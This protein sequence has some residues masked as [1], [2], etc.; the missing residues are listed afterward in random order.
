MSKARM[1]IAVQE[2]LHHKE[3]DIE[4]I[5]ADSELVAKML[6]DNLSEQEA[7]N[8]ISLPYY[9]Y[10]YK[11]DV[12]TF[13]NNNKALGS[14]ENYAGKLLINEK[15][16]FIRE[17]Y[18]PPHTTGQQI[19]FL[20][21]ILTHYPFENKYLKSHF[22]AGNHV[23]VDT[24]IT[25]NYVKDGYAVKS[26]TGETLFYMKYSTATIPDWVPD[27]MMLVLVFFA[28]LTAIAW[29]QLMSINISRRLSPMLGLI[30]TVAIVI[31]IRVLTYQFGLPFHLQSLP[32]F[33]SLI[34]A[35]SALHPSLGDLLLNALCGLWI[36]AYLLSN[37][38][39]INT[40]SER[41]NKPIKIFLI[42]FISSIII[43]SSFWFINIMGSLVI[44]SKI[45]FDVSHFYSI[46]KY[47]IYG[48]ITIGII[49]IA[50]CLL[51]YLLNIQLNKLLKNKWL[52]YLMLVVLGML[53]IAISDKSRTGE[54]SYYLLAWLLL[55]V[56]LLDI[57]QLTYSQD[58]LAPRM[59]FW[60][61]FVCVFCTSV[62]YYFNIQKEKLLRSY[63]AESIAEQRDYQVEDFSF[64]NVSGSIQ[65]DKVIKAF[66]RQPS[67]EMRRNLND[68]FGILYLGGQLSKYE[69]RVYIFD[70][71]GRSLFN[72]DTF[73]YNALR[74]LQQ[75]ARHTS[76]S[77][78]YFREGAQDGHY[79]LGIIPINNG[80][81]NKRLG[82]IF[83][84]LAIKESTGETVY[85]E[86]LQP[87]AQR[88]FENDAGYS[89]GIYINRK[90][91]TQSDDY[92]FPIFINRNPKSDYEYRDTK[93]ASELW[94]RA[95]NTKTVV[96]V[97]SSTLW[98]EVIT[99]FSYLFGIQ[100]MIA[101]LIVLYRS[102]LSYVVK[103]KPSRKLISFTLRRR[104]HFSMLGIVLVSFC[105]IGTVTTLYFTSQY[106]QNNR[107][108]LLS[109]MQLTE[110]SVMQYLIQNYGG[111]GIDAFN[112]AVNNPDF[113]YKISEIASGQKID[114]NIYGASG[115]LAATSQDN[116]YDRALLARIM[117]P[118]AYI[119]LSKRNSPLLMQ[120]ESVGLL[121]YLSCYVP[122]RDEG[123]TAIGYINIPYFSSQK[124]LRYQ[125]SNILVALINLYAFIFLL[126][127][128]FTVFI[129]QWIT[130]SFS[131]VINRFEKINL[132]QNELIEW[133][134]DDEI[135]VLV[136]EY[137]KMVKNVEENAVLLAKSER[138]GA[139]R[140]MAQ[141]VAHEIKNPLTPM[142]L[143]IQ[144]LQQAL[145]SNYENIGELTAK[146]SESLIEQIDNLSYI[147]SEFS[148]FAKMPEAKPENIDINTVITKA[149]ELYLNEDAVKMIIEQP[150]ENL[151][152]FA[153]RSQLL[154]VFTNLLQNA[155]QSIPEDKV[156]EVIVDIKKE[157]KTVLIAITDNGTGISKEVV[158]KIFEPYFTTKSSG[159]GLGLAMTKKIIEFWKGKIW[160]ETEEGK[161]TTFFIT[162]PLAQG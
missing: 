107:K 126:S 4:R 51:I 12:L 19:T 74:R 114:V 98:L 6:S 8:L 82:Y 91:L 135:G 139:W 42:I 146:V 84:D 136:K 49:T 50:C 65:G 15:G 150:E 63:F 43:I 149:A 13:W 144:Y 159:T 30:I 120:D 140:E 62:L 112:K 81:S 156:G 59:I 76:D 41:L 118:E 148:N 36:V 69:E 101:I 130:R 85:P 113:K 5:T 55:F 132:S 17:C 1:A 134:Y 143:N 3:R 14:C 119:E 75:N 32:I 86:L 137:N 61:F 121:S 9:I 16:V 95:N 127:G 33:S 116:I 138:E 46:N 78:L 117:R 133:P 115:I 145:K 151:F 28:L 122:I 34:F 99:L 27:I 105:I 58:I 56:I 47:T 40:D 70:A 93:S 152:V 154:R 23:P 45:S 147:A 87:N 157:N 20:I 18:A 92:T 129:T 94:Y 52:K 29:L 108:K 106:G 21:P 26:I 72:N 54:I 160:F 7:N 79:Y 111:T 77:M 67:K 161:G 38:S 66:L 48:L 125:I 124:E 100:V 35:T 37:V 158:D 22:E 39:V 141:Q 68:R 88:T 10:A 162:L 89:Y 96:V 2:D 131:I 109:E 24:R 97:H 57:K 142:K 44:D 104:I 103:Q 128:L 83:I 31:G 90:L 53:L 153:D 11:N 73:S 60:A 25:P 123:G 80:D 102:T 110:R 155:V 64:G 71:E